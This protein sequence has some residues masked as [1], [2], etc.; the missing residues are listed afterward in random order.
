MMSDGLGRVTKERNEAK[1]MLAKVEMDL[2]STR[3]EN[4]S[5]KRKKPDAQMV[6]ASEVGKLREELEK[7]RKTRRE[8]E[9]Q[10]EGFK[11]GGN[12]GS[13]IK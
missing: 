13:T 2:A 6:K 5:L 11:K 7:E 8:F 1:E 12:V 10:I 3:V 4:E 9:E